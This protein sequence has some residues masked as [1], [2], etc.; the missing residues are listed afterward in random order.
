MGRGERWGG[1]EEGEGEDRE[2]GKEK[3]LEPV[4]S[5]SLHNAL[6]SVSGKHAAEWAGI[7]G[8]DRMIKQNRNDRKKET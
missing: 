5:T 2:E 6:E 4:R 3:L 1:G 8:M 7:K